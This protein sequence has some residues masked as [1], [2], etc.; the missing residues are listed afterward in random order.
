MGNYRKKQAGFTLIEIMAFLAIFSFVVLAVISFFMWT[1]RSYYKI[2]A[3][4]EVLA[5]VSRAMNVITNEIKLANDVYAPTTASDQLSLVTNNEVPAGENST[6]VDIFN[7][8]GRICFKREGQ[9]PVAITSNEV[10]VEN[11]SFTQIA[12][13]SIASIEIVI[14]LKYNTNSTRADYQSSMQANSVA[15][16]R[17]Y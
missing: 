4:Q 1:S 10:V 5:N 11:L 17:D 3:S 15:S 8:G 12:T 16:L 9:A 2:N 14:G 7:C 13:S 6:F